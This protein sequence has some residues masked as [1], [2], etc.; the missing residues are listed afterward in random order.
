MPLHKYGT[1]V[2]FGLQIAARL[3][4]R[5]RVLHRQVSD[6]FALSM[7]YMNGIISTKLDNWKK[8]GADSLTFFFAIF[9]M[10]RKISLAATWWWITSPQFFTIVSRTYQ[11][12]IN[13]S[14]LTLIS[15]TNKYSRIHRISQTEKSHYL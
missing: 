10:S 9:T 7:N 3:N 11:Q 12:R 8:I 2:C 5:L 14:Y 1:K 15:V 6:I 13:T 4:Y